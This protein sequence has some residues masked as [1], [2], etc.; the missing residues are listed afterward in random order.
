MLKSGTVPSVFPQYPSYLKPAPSKPRGARSI[1]KRKRESSP[2]KSA[3]NCASENITGVRSTQQHMSDST[4]SV[5]CM[6]MSVSDT[7]SVASQDLTQQFCTSRTTENSAER[8]DLTCTERL[9]HPGQTAYAMRS[10]GTQ[11]NERSSSAAFL[12]RKKWHE[13]ER[14]LKAQNERL[15]STV[16]AYKKELQQMKE[17]CHVSKF[18]HVVKNS[19]LACTK[20]KI[21]LDQVVN[22]KA[23]KPIWSE[24]TIRQCTILRQL[25]AKCYEHMRT[26]NLLSFPCRNTLK[27]YLGSSSGEVGFSEL[28]KRRL[29]AELE[30]LTTPNQNYVASS[31]M[32]CAFDRSLSTTS[33]EMHFLETLT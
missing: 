26:K 7:D 1:A 19:E 22:Y 25:S 30:C 8:P 12:Q 32:R 17:Q 21:I 23:K 14:T 24:T 28:V 33:N 2:T 15:R 5:D 11:T 16:D 13:K 18:L 29:S 9:P 20:A 10:F 4:V 6:V 31:W 27:K 3:L